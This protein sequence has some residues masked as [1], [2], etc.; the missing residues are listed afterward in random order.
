MTHSN[1]SGIGKIARQL[2]FIARADNTDQASIPVNDPNVPS[3]QRL[4]EDSIGLGLGR[5][6]T[7]G[8]PTNATDVRLSSNPDWYVSASEDSL[9]R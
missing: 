2:V 3:L 4:V 8:G 9:T 6:T 1:S 7:K 5:E